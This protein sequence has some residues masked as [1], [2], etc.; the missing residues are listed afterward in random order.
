MDQ[1]TFQG[2][3]TAQDLANALLAR[4][5]QGDLRAQQRGRGGSLVMQTLKDTAIA[6]GASYEIS[7]HLRRLTCPYCA[8][9]NPVGD[10]S[11]I[12]CGAPLGYRQ[13]VACNNC[14]FVTEAG[15]LT[16]PKCGLPLSS[17]VSA[18]RS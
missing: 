2:S 15:A 4:F 1:R 6:L 13:P 17:S 16:C 18:V 12:A 7:E 5:N 8:T 10:P 11:C 14:G 3:L 9:A